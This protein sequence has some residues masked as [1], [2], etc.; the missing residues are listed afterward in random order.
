MKKYLIYKLLKINVLACDCDGQTSESDVC[1]P[2]S[3]QCRQVASGDH[4]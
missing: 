3:G 4:V 2:E 1:D